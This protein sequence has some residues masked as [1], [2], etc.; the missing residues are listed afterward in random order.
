MTTQNFKII[1]RPLGVCFRTTVPL[2]ATGL[3]LVSGCSRKAP[4]STSRRGA[5]TPIPVL[6][7]MAI[8]TNVPI[9]LRAIGSV[10]PYA[11]VSVKP[12]VDG[13][14]QTVVFRQ[15]D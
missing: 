8:E 6:A 14:L 4:P 15:G 2:L 12:R 1:K 9:R 3:M 7:A 5:A 10:S 13:Q 11:T